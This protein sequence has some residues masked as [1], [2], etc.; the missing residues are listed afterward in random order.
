MPPFPIVLG[1]KQ[2]KDLRKPRLHRPS[3]HS[4]GPYAHLIAFLLCLSDRG[5]QLLP[6]PFFLVASLPLLQTSAQQG[7]H[8]ASAGGWIVLSHCFCK[9]KPRLY[10]ACS[11]CYPV[12]LCSSL[13]PPRP[14]Q[15]HLHPWG[16]EGAVCDHLPQ[17]GRMP[18]GWGGCG[19]STIF[20][21]F[22]PCDTVVLVS[23]SPAGK[24][25]D[26]GWLPGSK[27]DKSNQCLVASW[28]QGRT[29]QLKKIN[30]LDES[31]SPSSLVLW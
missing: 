8:L 24:G 26:T 12:R 15:H 21:A 19:E 5:R 16:E 2:P 14:L 20:L 28:T 31:P 9:A 23:L 30:A 7:R 1:L 29:T 6:R 22:P 27:R 4:A 3:R 18:V 10:S 13:T 17:H 11:H 25:S